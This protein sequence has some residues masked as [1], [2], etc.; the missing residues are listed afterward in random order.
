MPILSAPSIQ[1]DDN[2]VGDGPEHICMAEKN[3]SLHSIPSLS[4]NCVVTDGH[5]TG[6]KATR[7]RAA[8]V[9]RWTILHTNVIESVFHDLSGDY[10]EDEDMVWD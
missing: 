7:C 5:W 2:C 10:H 8:L 6:D 4:S 9:F 1:C 3:S